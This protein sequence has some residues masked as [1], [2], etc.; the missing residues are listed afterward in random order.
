MTE[1]KI[2]DID[3]IKLFEELNMFSKITGPNISPN[4]N[5]S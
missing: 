3:D 2:S 4:K 5:P 1:N